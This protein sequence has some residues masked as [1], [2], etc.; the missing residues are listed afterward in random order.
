V[1]YHHVKKCKLDPEGLLLAMLQAG[2]GSGTT[3]HVG[4]QPEDT[5]ASRAAGVMALGAAWGIQ[6]GA[7][8]EA[9]KPDLIFKLVEQCRSFLLNKVG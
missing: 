8:L 6:D 4:D 3:F 7:A 5:E 1:G 2:A 9:S